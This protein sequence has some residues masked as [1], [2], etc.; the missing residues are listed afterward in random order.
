MC[1]QIKYTYISSFNSLGGF[2]KEMR[3]K[4]VQFNGEDA[5]IIYITAEEKKD[6]SIKKSIDV[7]KRSYRHVAVFESGENSI[8]DLLVRIIQEKM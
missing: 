7:Y 6:E 2:I 1:Y 8:E 3:V 5:L 4:K